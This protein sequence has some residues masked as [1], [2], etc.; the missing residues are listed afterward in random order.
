ME[1]ECRVEIIAIRDHVPLM[2]GL[3]TFLCTCL[4]F[5]SPLFVSS[6]CQSS[7]YSWKASSNARVYEK[8]LPSLLPSSPS[9][10]PQPRSLPATLWTL[11]EWVESS[12]V[13]NPRV[14][15]PGMGDN[16]YSLELWSPNESTGSA[17]GPLMLIL[18]IFIHF[19]SLKMKSSSSWTTR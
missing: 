2:Q 9:S 15:A 14:Q 13:L 4:G 6:S 16:S 12:L 17:H 3:A 18:L 7:I 19:F 1:K 5:P 11:I 10:S 8:L